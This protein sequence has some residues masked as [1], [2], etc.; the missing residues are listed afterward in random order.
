M[1]TFTHR[2][3][4]LASLG[5]AMLLGLSGG[6]AN[7]DIQPVGWAVPLDAHMDVD[8]MVQLKRKL[9]VDRPQLE[10]AHTNQPPAPPAPPDAPDSPLRMPDIKGIDLV[11]E[12]EADVPARPIFELPGIGNGGSVLGPLPGLDSEFSVFGGE[13]VLSPS[14]DRGFDVIDGS[15]IG[16]SGFQG[17]APSVVPGPGAMIL[18]LGAGLAGS[19]RRRR[20]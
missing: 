16:D 5:A 8:R 6:T 13:L 2:P 15:S 17:Q 7:A 9:K 12:L 4:F 3:L 14:R 11:P 19:G 1:T 20:D 18:L 10:T